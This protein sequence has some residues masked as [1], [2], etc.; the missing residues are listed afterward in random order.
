MSNYKI[1]PCKH[2][3]LFLRCLTCKGNSPPCHH[4]K[5]YLHFLCQVC[6]ISTLGILVGLNWI[7]YKTLAYKYHT[8]AHGHSPYNNSPLQSFQLH[9]SSHLLCNQDMEHQGHFSSP[10]N[11]NYI[12]CKH[13]H[14]IDSSQQDDR[15][16]SHI[17]HSWYQ[18]YCAD[19]FGRH[20]HQNKIQMSSNLIDFQPLS[21]YTRMNWN[22]YGNCKVDKQRLY[23][24]QKGSQFPVSMDT[25]CT[26]SSS[27]HITVHK[28]CFGKSKFFRQMLHLCCI[29]MHAHCRSNCQ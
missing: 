12:L 5:Y 1:D 13:Q 3:K 17:S 8:F 6:D 21:G 24:L 14:L 23:P 27:D 18:W 20:H 22:G 25:G 19:N 16:R 9:W 11:Y 10:R 15:R 26:L 28:H 7:D 2:H 29:L 4:C